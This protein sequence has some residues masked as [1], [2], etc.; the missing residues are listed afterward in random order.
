[1]DNLLNPTTGDY[2]GTTTTTLANAVY[3]RVKTPLGSYWADPLLGS[4]LH[5]LAREK[6]V[7]RVHKL[8]QQY[9]AEALQPIVDDGRASAVSVSASAGNPGWL[10]LLIEVTTTTQQTQTFRHPVRVS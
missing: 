7:A 2:T 8:A 10:M 9:A 5:L 3:L 1:M 6:D 4:K